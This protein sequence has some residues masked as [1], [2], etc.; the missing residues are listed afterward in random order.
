M[1]LAIALAVVAVFVSGAALAATWNADA[2]QLRLRIAIVGAHDGGPWANLAS[3]QKSKNLPGPP[4]E[5]PQAP[6]VRTDVVV[7]PI[8]KVGEVTVDLELAGSNAAEDRDLRAALV[9]DGVLFVADARPEHR[10]AN[11]RRFAQLK[12]VLGAIDSDRFVVQ[13][14]RGEGDGKLSEDALREDLSLP[15]E[16]PVFRADA[17]VGTGVLDSLKPLIKSALKREKR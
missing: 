15:A 8:G 6:E 2:K 14:D 11:Q 16:I 12:R 1:S 4:V 17:A 7:L 5:P 13:L 3:L 10:E 9:G